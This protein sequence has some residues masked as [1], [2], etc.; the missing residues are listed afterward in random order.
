MACVRVKTSDTAS[1]NGIYTSDDGKIK[2]YPV[3]VGM[4]APAGGVFCP[5][6]ASF[7]KDEA[8]DKAVFQKPTFTPTFTPTSGPTSLPTSSPTS[9]PTWMPTASPTSVPT[10][11]CRYDTNKDGSCQVSYQFAYNDSWCGDGAVLQDNYPDNTTAYQTQGSCEALCDSNPSCAFFVFGYDTAGWNRCATFRN[12]DSRSVYDNG[13][14]NV[15]A[16]IVCLLHTDCSRGQVCSNYQCNSCSSFSS[17]SC[18]VDCALDDHGRCT[19]CEN[20]DKLHCIAD[21]NRCLGYS[22]NGSRCVQCS[23]MT[24][25]SSCLSAICTWIAGQGCNSLCSVMPYKDPS[26]WCPRGDVCAPSLYCKACKPPVG[27]SR[28]RFEGYCSARRR[29]GVYTCV[30]P[31]TQ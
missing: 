29:V 25:S 23:S 6:Q 14:P 12:C 26:G 28:R 3:S 21:D 18:P 9:V 8:F 4:T 2:D 30:Q 24:S 16:K 5:A 10:Q 1:T 20:A 27:C 22:W 17:S 7:V 19:T 13:D 31:S 11:F 15:Y